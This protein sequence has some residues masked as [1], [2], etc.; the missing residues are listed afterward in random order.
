MN[1][2]DLESLYGKRD[3]IR[4]IL[5]TYEKDWDVV[6]D[7]VQ[8]VFAAALDSEYDEKS[9]PLTW[10]CGIAKNVGGHHVE[11][12]NRDK[13]KYEILESELGVPLDDA[14]CDVPYY[15]QVGG[16][17]T[18]TQL[19]ANLDPLLELEAEDVLDAALSSM[20]PKMADCVRMRRKGYNNHEVADSLGCTIEHVYNLMSKARSYFDEN[21]DFTR[22]NRVRA[23]EDEHKF[24]LLDWANEANAL[25]KRA[26]MEDVIAQQRRRYQVAD[27]AIAARNA[28]I[29]GVSNA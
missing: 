17:T 7:L 1:G 23:S 21:Q 13:R 20:P 27:F 25:P 26:S 15:D 22:T 9:T 19:T 12:Q 2:K 6:D 10:I 3:A 11:S 18:G 24:S 8:D 14:D 4:K 16:S 28:R 5:H 29:M